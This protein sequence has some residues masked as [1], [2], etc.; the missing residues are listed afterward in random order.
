MI[1]IVSSQFD[2]TGG[3]VIKGLEN[4]AKNFLD[5]H[6]IPYQ[7]IQVPGAV[8]IPVT[9]QHYLE[10]NLSP[11]PNG[12]PRNFS[13]AIALGCVIKGD[14]DHYELV[15]NSAMQG[16]TQLALSSKT[17]IIQGILA[18]RTEEDALNRKD[19]GREYAETAV[20][21]ME[22]VNKTTR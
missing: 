21:M 20:N 16:L 6:Q 3:Q 5:E 15:I 22:I 10:K 11:A 8:E 4:S 9:I 14:T 7:H 17:P 19:H 1:L 18:C 2:K 12:E 13:A